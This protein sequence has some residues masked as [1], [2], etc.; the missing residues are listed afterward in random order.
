MRAMKSKL[1][2]MGALVGLALA[3][4]VA[5]LWLGGG[6]DAVTAPVRRRLPPEAYERRARAA[7][8]QRHPGEKPLNWRI[9][10]TA[11]RFHETRPMGRF[12]LHENDCSDFVGCIIDEA[13][14]PGARFNRDSTEHAL[15]GKGGALRRELFDQRPLTEVEAVQPGDVLRVRHSPWYAPHDDTIGH[16]GVVGPQGK[17]LDFVKLKSWREA[18]YGRSG[19]AW[20]IRH[21]EPEEVRVCRL[22]P[23]FRY[24]IQA[25]P[26]QLPRAHQAQRAHGRAGA[27]GGRPGA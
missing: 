11:L 3:G 25:L 22:R 7:F 2:I 15:C 26:T 12:I 23:Q 14:G 8:L 18:R 5:W 10:R 4:G 24:R 17:V 9:A 6:A 27:A 1:A 21:N 19:L 16:V 20:F 13:L